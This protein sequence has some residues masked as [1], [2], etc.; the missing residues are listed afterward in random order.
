VDRVLLFKLG[1]QLF[2]GSFKGIAFLAGFPG[3]VD[4]IRNLERRII[5]AQGLAGGLDFVLAQRCTV[6]S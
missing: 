4:L 6:G 3:L 1:K 2:P 5:P